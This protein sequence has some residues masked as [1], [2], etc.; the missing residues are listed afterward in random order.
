MLILLVMSLP[1][2]MSAPSDWVASSNLPVWASGPWSLQSGMPTGF[3]SFAG[4]VSAPRRRLPL[5]PFHLL[6][7]TSMSLP[8]AA[9]VICKVLGK[10]LQP[11]QS[12]FPRPRGL[13][14]RQ[15]NAL[16]SDSNRYAFVGREKCVQEESPRTPVRPAADDVWRFP[17]GSPAVLVRTRGFALRARIGANCPFGETRPARTAG[18]FRYKFNLGLDFA[19]GQRGSN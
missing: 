18:R 15:A 4:G 17:F 5:L 14:T 3:L 6:S 9:A 12:L 19:Y 7:S 10:T 1:A 13:S 16:I 11:A 2:S 8:D